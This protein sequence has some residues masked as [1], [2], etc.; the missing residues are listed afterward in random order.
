MEIVF[1]DPEP[2]DTAGGGIRTYAR[3]AMAA[4]REAGASARVYT[5]NPAAYPGERAAPIGRL[6]WLPRP[7]RGLAY[8]LGYGQN[9]LWEHARW[10]ERELAAADAPGRVYEFADYLGYAFFAL[11][12]PRLRP[13]CIVR[14]HTPAFLIAPVPQGIRNRLFARLSTWREKDSLTRASFLVAPS[15]EF[16]R[17]KLPWLE[18]WKHVPNPLPPNPQLP[19]GSSLRAAR[20]DQAERLRAAETAAQPGPLPDSRDAAWSAAA[21]DPVAVAEAARAAA[22]P[23]RILASRFLYLGRVETRKGVMPLVQAFARLAVERP[24]ACL[25]LVGPIGEA[26]YAKEVADAIAALPKAIRDRIEWEPPCA[27][28]GRAALFARHTALVVPSLWENSPYVYFEG[29]AAGLVC[30]GSATGEMKAVA[31]AT[32]APSPAPGNPDDWVA[33]LRAHCEG[34][35]SDVPAAQKAYLASRRAGAAAGLM[36]AWSAAGEAA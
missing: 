19:A 36:A 35:D 12:N 14:V 10:L 5:H 20:T 33:S 25:T 11:R 31:R 24:F 15:A 21:P 8:R 16:M 29:M 28:S 4:C 32:G 3:L 13:R 18:G 26:G 34:K 9:A 1:I 23:D 17:E 22:R 30:I 7:L 27:P 6:P 2:P